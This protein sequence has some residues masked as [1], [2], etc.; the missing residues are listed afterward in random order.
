MH[1]HI[2][3]GLLTDRLIGT[4]GEPNWNVVTTRELEH[5]CDMIAM[6]M[7]DHNAGDILGKLAD[8]RQTTLGFFDTE[9]T[10]KHDRGGDCGGG[11]ASCTGRDDQCITFAAAA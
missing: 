2:L 4:I 10:I 7:R 6:L 1:D 11:S 8:T 9:T 3:A 5:T